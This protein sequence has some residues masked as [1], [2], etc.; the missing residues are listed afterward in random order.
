MGNLN[1]TEKTAFFINL[2]HIMISH[3]YLVLGLPPSNGFK[4]ISHFNMISY[5]CAD[6][7]FSLAELEHCIIRD[8]MSY[9]FNN[10]AL[11]KNYIIPKSK[12]EMALSINDF[13][14]NFALNC[15]SVSNPETI[16]V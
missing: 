2:Y 1:S 7:I 12:Y 15:G 14:I 3:S 10:N 8:S 5:Q 16:P 11:V 6:E 4:W 9:P 13:R